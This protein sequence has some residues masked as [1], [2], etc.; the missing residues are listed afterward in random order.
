MLARNNHRCRA[1]AV[2]GKHG[3]RLRARC[4]FDHNQIA[5]I[6]FTD[7]GASS[8]ESYTVDR[9]KLWKRGKIDGHLIKNE[10]AVRA[11][12]RVQCSASQQVL[13]PTLHSLNLASY[14]CCYAR[15]P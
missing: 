7:A 13:L 11:S 6:W 14:A 10:D 1:K 12:G 4:A 8:A 3:R 5:T 15:R 2:L 9:M